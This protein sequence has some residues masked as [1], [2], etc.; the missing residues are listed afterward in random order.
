[1]LCPHISSRTKTRQCECLATLAATRWRSATTT[2]TAAA[3]LS[4]RR[5][6]TGR[7]LPLRFVSMTDS[8]SGRFRR[9]SDLVAAQQQL[10][11]LPAVPTAGPDEENDFGSLLVDVPGRDIRAPAGV[12]SG[13]PFSR[14][15]RLLNP[16][17]SS[18]PPSPKTEFDAEAQRLMHPL[19]ASQIASSAPAI[20]AARN[21]PC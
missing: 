20:T 18:C 1:M 8:M 12:A 17:H 9:C 11:D 7:A 14:Q 5:P 4:D 13:R 6:D 21:A 19:R 10:Y 16:R 3:E 15:W 2:T